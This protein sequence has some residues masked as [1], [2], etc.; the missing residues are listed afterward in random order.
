MNIKNSKEIYEIIQ[1]HID[2]KMLLNVERIFNNESDIICGFPIKMSDDLLLTTVVNDFH[3][4]G[5]SILRLS[6]ITDAYST[7]TI[8]FYEKICIA[9]GLQNEIRQQI[10]K[11][12]D[13]MHQILLQLKSYKGFISIQCENQIN[14]STFYLGEIV[15]VEDDGVNF[16]D[17]GIDGIWDD[18]IHKITY[19]DI[20]QITYGNKYSKMYYKYSKNLI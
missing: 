9:E 19:E 8:A 20:S 16:K 2:N 4:E 11:E 12:L 10:I 15:T 13:D 6:D 3:N 7:E 5:F 1:Y 14:K 18:D 17:I